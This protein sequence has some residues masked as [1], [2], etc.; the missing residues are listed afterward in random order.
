MIIIVMMT[1]MIDIIRMKTILNVITGTG[2]AVKVKL[3]K[4]M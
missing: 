3:E 1:M 2:H 4:I